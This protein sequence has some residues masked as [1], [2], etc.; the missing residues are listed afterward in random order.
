MSKYF[1]AEDVLRLLSDEYYSQGKAG[2]LATWESIKSLPTIEVEGGDLEDAILLTKDA[3]S[4]LCLRASQVSDKAECDN[5]IWN[6]CNYNKIDFEV[7]EDC[8]SREYLE[9]QLQQIE[10]ITAMAHIDLGE[11][12][13]DETE[14]ITMPIS[15]VR[16]IFKNAPS[17]VPTTENE[18][19]LCRNC[20]NAYLY[21]DCLY[22]D[23]IEEETEIEPNDACSLW[24]L[25]ER[26]E[27]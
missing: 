6:V 4:D 14:E 17:V 26:I 3:Y 16:K 1:K 11:D 27:E 8:I 2:N 22:C 15:T 23:E 24:K 20:D 21:Q 18:I 9:E 19:K 13:Y 12:P 7:S 5:C 10:D 25:R